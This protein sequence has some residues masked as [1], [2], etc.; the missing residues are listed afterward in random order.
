M[1]GT[2][3]GSNQSPGTQSYRKAL[4]QE[5]RQKLA[6]LLQ[7]TS[8]EADVKMIS[9]DLKTLGVTEALELNTLEIA[10]EG[11][12]KIPFYFNTNRREVSLLEREETLT[13]T[14]F[15]SINTLLALVAGF[16]MTKVSYKDW[17]TKEEGRSIN[18]QVGELDSL[19]TIYSEL[20]F[21]LELRDEVDF[22]YDA[23]K[24]FNKKTGGF[25]RLVNIYKDGI[26]ARLSREVDT[27][28]VSASRAFIR[29]D[30][31][32]YN[33]ELFKNSQT[34][35]FL[36]KNREEFLKLDGQSRR[37]LEDYLIK[38]RALEK[39][40]HE[41]I[42]NLMGFSRDCLC[43]RSAL[44]AAKLIAFMSFSDNRLKSRIN[45]VLKGKVSG[46]TVAHIASDLKTTP[47]FLWAIVCSAKE[48]QLIFPKEHEGRNLMNYYNFYMRKYR[49][50]DNLAID[51]LGLVNKIV[52]ELSESIKR[53]V[54]SRLSRYNKIRNSNPNL[55]K[56]SEK[57]V[58]LQW[59]YPEWI[60]Y[61][62]KHNQLGMCLEETLYAIVTGTLTT[63]DESI[64][65]SAM[66]SP[67]VPQ[68]GRYTYQRTIVDSLVT[69]R[70]ST[71]I[72]NQEKLPFAMAFISS[73][74]TKTSG[75]SQK[76]IDELNLTNNKLA[77]KSSLVIKK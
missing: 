52:N 24:R 23:I 10:A 54:Y 53:V 35:S 70:I 20:S 64:Q 55:F 71:G 2:N 8:A 42:M 40:T 3:L 29:N 67:T 17:S 46:M 6:S 15:S 31:E 26:L 75:I 48:L 47:L 34:V 41:N 74:V 56:K 43:Y 50:G 11:K 36:F 27:K 4:S 76:E 7:G 22:S 13:F 45:S 51:K 77:D 37:D 60:D 5:T 32:D 1:S 49:G 21:A 44:Q 59:T 28:Y 18:L 14:K 39:K 72:F 62:Y 12:E 66:L 19:K 61:N 69:R 16:E 30:E 68:Q 9:E 57:G 25:F 58:L 33:S 73:I 65:L 38:I 63:I